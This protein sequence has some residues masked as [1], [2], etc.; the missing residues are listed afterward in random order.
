MPV[1]GQPRFR[2]IDPAFDRL[3]HQPVDH[4]LPG[5]FVVLHMLML[6]G[7]HANRIEAVHSDGFFD[8][9]GFILGLGRE[10][11]AKEAGVMLALAADQAGQSFC[12]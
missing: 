9:P 10:I 11:P 7:F 4:R 6:I 8:F 3:Q 12:R 1:R 5:R 2:D